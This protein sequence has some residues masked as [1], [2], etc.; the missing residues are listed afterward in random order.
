MTSEYNIS[1]GPNETES[2]EDLK[3]LF[4]YHLS[5]HYEY[6]YGYDSSL[7][8]LEESIL[9][10]LESK[11][12][13]INYL[14]ISSNC[15]DTVRWPVI[16]IIR[17]M[18]N[19]KTLVLSDNSILDEEEYYSLSEAFDK[20]TNLTSINLSSCRIKYGTEI[21]ENLRNCTGLTHLDLSKNLIRSGVESLAK[22]EFKKLKYIDLSFNEIEP[23]G[24][25]SLLEV[26]RLN[27]SLTYVHFN[28]N[29]LG[30]EGVKSLIEVLGELK[31]LTFCDL[32]SNMIQEEEQ[33]S[34]AEALGQSSVLV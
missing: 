16:D 23:E 33:S 5:S 29:K 14:E 22:A 24:A 21:F 10:E 17:L 6:E 13:D 27:K 25:T 26:L 7:R 30:P 3:R 28:D 18:T 15:I 8:K 11:E 12:L 19:I 32:R 4:R 34:I 31:V 2:H 1:F 20:L 9:K